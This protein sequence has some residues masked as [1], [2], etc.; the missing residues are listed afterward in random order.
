MLK[1]LNLI[2]NWKEYISFF[3]TLFFIKYSFIHLFGFKT[4]LNF[5]DFF[6][7]TIASISIIAIGDFLIYFYSQSTSP[8]KIKRK[9]VILFCLIPLFLCLIAILLTFIKIGNINIIFIYLLLILVTLFH[10]TRNRKKTLLNNIIISSY[11]PLSIIFLWYI[12]FPIDITLKQL[13]VILQ[14]EVI[15][16]YVIIV[17]FF[18]NLNKHI[19]IDL[20]N[21]K[22]DLQKKT[23]NITYCFW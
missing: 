12:A 14:L 7:L 9:K 13:Q 5:P 17:S 23:Q 11:K 6:T 10:V 21:K 2:F 18:S 8:F 16:L 20:K 19:L 22:R 15:L 1:K 3:L 4:R